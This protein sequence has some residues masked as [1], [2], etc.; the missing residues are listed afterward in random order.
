[1]KP[2]GAY[3]SLV[4]PVEAKQSLMKPNEENWN[5]VEPIEA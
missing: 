1:M 5:L 4:D 3:S 2:S